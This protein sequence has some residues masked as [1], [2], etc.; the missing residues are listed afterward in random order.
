MQR[1]SSPQI[2]DTSTK[3]RQVKP[4]FPSARTIQPPY[5]L[6]FIYN[7]LGN[8]QEVSSDIGEKKKIEEKKWVN[9]R[10]HCCKDKSDVSIFTTSFPPPH[11]PTEA[12]PA[13]EPASHLT[14]LQEQK[15]I[16]AKVHASIDL[17]SSS[18]FEKKMAE[19]HCQ[20][21]IEVESISTRR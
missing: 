2:T 18:Q 17:N 9:L 16:S 1:Y 4:S 13:S 21:N 15:N 5:S 12:V 11:P 3:K 8:D 6:R 10:A 7:Q 19:L 14:A 20:R